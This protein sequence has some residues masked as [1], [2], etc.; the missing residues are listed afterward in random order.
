MAGAFVDIVLNALF[1]R[2]FGCIGASVA[3]LIAEMVQMG[4]QLFYSYKDVVSGFQ[5][6][7]FMHIGLLQLFLFLLFVSW[8]FC[9]DFQ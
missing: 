3:T 8:S 6:K 5:L 1:M 2:R 4:V 7:T 9:V